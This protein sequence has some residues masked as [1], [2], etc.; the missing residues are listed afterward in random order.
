MQNLPSDAHVIPNGRRAYTAPVVGLSHSAAGPGFQL[1]VYSGDEVRTLDLPPRGTVSIGRG[2]GSAV[3]IDDLSVS[4]NHAVLHLGDKVVIEDLGSNNGTTIQDRAGGG[5][6]AE[7]LNVRQLR[8]RKAELAAGQSIV[9][10]TVRVVIRRAPTVE[11]PS[12]AAADPGESGGDDGVLV[13]D[14]AMKALYAEAAAAARTP[15]SVL[16]LGEMGVGKE[17]FARAIH[18]G[19]P[20]SKGPFVA[21]NCSALTETM[22]EDE[23]F[24]HEKGSFT[25]AQKAREGLLASANGGTVFLDEIGDLAPAAQAKLLRVLEQREVRPV[26]SDRSRPI[27]VRFVAATNRDLEHDQ[28]AEPFRQDLLFRLNT[29]TLHIPPLRSRRSEILPLARM[30]LAA[31]CRQIERPEPPA[32]SAAAVELL[33]MHDWPGNVRELRNAMDRVAAL[34][35]PDTVL[36]EHLPKGLRERKPPPPPSPTTAPPPPGRAGENLASELGDIEKARIIEMLQRWGGNVSEAAR[37]L[38]IS[39]GTLI[40][41]MEE[42]GLP[43]ARKRRDDPDE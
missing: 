39:R 30:F 26:G 17:L 31:A 36:P 21:I 20:R 27:D 5:S 14:P 25:S 32:L 29:I 16:V 8:A 13:R 42:Y 4:R 37:R 10:G 41:R 33:E 28:R 40:A 12:L 38:G 35:L 19:S 6:A 15:S 1:V 23:L 18:A 9:F 22:L 24:G 43:R 11:V 34:C 7:T 3:R 2:E